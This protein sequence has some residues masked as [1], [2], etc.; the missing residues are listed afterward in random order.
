MTV[1]QIAVTL[2][3]LAAVAWIVKYFWLHR[4]PG[5]AANVVAGVQELAITVQG[6]Y[7]PDV[8]TVRRSLPVRLRFT[9]NESSMCSETVVFDGIERSAYLP[10][11]K[12]V[13]I[14]FTPTAAG[15]IAFHCQ[16]NMLRGKVIVTP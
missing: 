16:M 2:G 6:G 5:V 7:D 3:G 12:T 1:L 8:V 4:P 14:E 11:G 13:N 15:E 9:R 10:E